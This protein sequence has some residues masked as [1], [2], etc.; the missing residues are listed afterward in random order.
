MNSIANCKQA[1]AVSALARPKRI[2]AT[3]RPSY[4]Q[5]ALN[6]GRDDQASRNPQKNSLFTIRKE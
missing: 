1:A 2:L 3:P 5:A 6:G 4:A